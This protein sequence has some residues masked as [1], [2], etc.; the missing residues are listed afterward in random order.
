M[1][2]PMKRL[3]LSVLILAGCAEEGARSGGGMLIT[4]DGRFIANT[5]RNAK[6]E[7]EW[8]IVVSVGERLGSSW[9]VRAQLQELPDLV[10]GDDM[11]S[12]EWRWP[13]A[14]AKVVL[15][16]SGTPAVPVAEIKSG[17]ERFLTRKLTRRSTGV[18]EVTVEVQAVSAAVPDT[19]VV[20]APPAGPR[21]YTAQP[22]DTWADVST[23]FYGSPEG[24]RTI[25]DANGGTERPA[26]GTV[27]TIPAR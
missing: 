22:G 9:Q 18:V 2:P 20:V 16:G 14:H 25:R 10:G 8:A 21:R 26:A 7:T 17:V 1:L 23:A 15:I 27:L 3:L 24:W 4:S 5:D 11:T 6:A 19:T 13:A 12:S